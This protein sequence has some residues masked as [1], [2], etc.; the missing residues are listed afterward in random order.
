M[1]K[2]FLI[3]LLFIAFQ[4][5]CSAPPANE[6]AANGTNDAGNY[7]NVPTTPSA[8]GM[9]Q[10]EPSA[11]TLS[12]ALTLLR[13]K[14]SAPAEISTVFVRD[15]GIRLNISTVEKGYLLAI[16]KGSDG[17]AQVL[18]PNKDYFNGRNEIELNKNV[19]IPNKGW[20]FFDEKKGT[21]TIFVVFSKT[22][23][24]NDL[25]A[26]PKRAVASFEK[27]RAEKNNPESFTT[28]N[29]ELVRVLEIKHI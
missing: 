12:V 28:A 4:A 3:G 2:F 26:D 21:E 13:N 22:G 19:V 9:T 11:D 24:L 20:F 7:G 16:Y 6:A 5:A 23:K 8:N 27:V 10:I 17:D 25:S 18:F 15:D 29:G 1:K 14:K